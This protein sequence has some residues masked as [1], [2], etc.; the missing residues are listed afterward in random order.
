MEELKNL[1]A[2]ELFE[3]EKQKR[4]LYGRKSEKSST[5]LQSTD[6]DLKND[7]DDFDG[8][9]PT[10]NESSTTVA[11]DMNIDCLP[12]L[13][14]LPACRSDYSKRSTRV[15][16][17]VMHYCDESSIPSDARK[18]DIRHWILYKLDWSVTKHVFELLRVI[19]QEGTISNYYERLIPM[20]LYVL[21]TMSFRVIM[22][23]WI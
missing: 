14:L 7:K 17:V 11:S 18:I 3:L 1:R 13:V 9:K 10:S 8:S 15:D 16:N 2:S 4:Q 19:D 23:I 12:P 20:I 21:L 22:W 5:L 6:K